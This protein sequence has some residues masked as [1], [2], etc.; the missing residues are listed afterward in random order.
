MSWKISVWIWHTGTLEVDPWER[1]SHTEVPVFTFTLAKLWT[2]QLLNLTLL[3]LDVNDACVFDEQQIAWAACDWLLLLSRALLWIFFS[4]GMSVML[5]MPILM[6][7]GSAC[8]RPQTKQQN[9]GSY[10]CL[11]S[12]LNPGLSA[13]FISSVMQQPW[14]ACRWAKGGLY[15]WPQ[16]TPNSIILERVSCVSSSER[17]FTCAEPRCYFASPS[18]FIIMAL[19]FLFLWGKVTN[20]PVLYPVFFRP[21]VFLVVIFLWYEHC[22]FDIVLLFLIFVCLQLKLFFL[23]TF[24]VTR[25]ASFDCRLFQL[26]NICICLIHYNKI[27]QYL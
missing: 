16:S 27:H 9:R 1:S 22:W 26:I 8:L 17:L 25:L 20:T 23:S 21:S 13:S 15:A 18:V 4:L 24:Y 10:T 5:G 3:A 19:F 7:K 12:P 11:P 14:P 6:P 2:Q